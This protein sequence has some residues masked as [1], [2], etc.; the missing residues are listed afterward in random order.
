MNLFRVGYEVKTSG[1]VVSWVSSDLKETQKIKIKSFVEDSSSP[2]EKSGWLWLVSVT[3][4]RR[5]SGDR[6]PDP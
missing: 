3:E 4:W 6:S 1:Y 2:V 5:T